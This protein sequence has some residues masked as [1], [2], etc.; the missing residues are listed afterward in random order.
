MVVGP[1]L[2]RAFA[3]LYKDL[4]RWDTTFFRG[5]GWRWSKEYFVPIGSLV[6]RRILEVD[7]RLPDH[8]KPIIEKISFGGELVV[9]QTEARKGYKGRLFWAH[10]GDFIYSKIRVKQGSCTIIPA[11]IP[12]IAVSAEYPVYSIRIGK[13]LPNYFALLIRCA[14]FMQVLDGLSHGS[15]TKTRI[16]PSQFEAIRIPIPPLPVQ[17]TIV[18]RWEQAQKDILAARQA[19][20]RKESEPRDVVSN[21]LGIATR[22]SH[23]KLRFFAVC[24][25][26]ISRWGFDMCWNAIYKLPVS[27]FSTVRVKEICH[28]GS[29]G[30]PSRKINAYFDDGDIPWVKTTEVRNEVIINTEEKITRLG[31]ENSAAKLYPPGSLL[32]A[33][34]GQGATRG[35]TAKLGIE[36]ATNQACCVLYKIDP[37]VDIDYLWFFLISEYDE[38]RKLASGNNQP[39]LNSE[40]I[41]NYEIPLPPLEQQRQI[42]EQV[43]ALRLVTANCRK[44]IE[45][46][47]RTANAEIEDMIMGSSISCCAPAVEVGAGALRDD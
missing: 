33:M 38:L 30:T 41:A 9:T 18:A 13:V 21:E 3:I 40:M 31:L 17:Q 2:P 4:E 6:E 43:N 10:G 27:K 25:N 14:P 24:W 15:S 26:K 12:S 47:T 11:T 23:I 7:P 34:Y 20:A 16:H 29:G 36:A 39:N 42:V 44:A 19:I 46:F 5:V 35:R 1:A 8:E 37:R 45:A 22:S 32:V 28:M